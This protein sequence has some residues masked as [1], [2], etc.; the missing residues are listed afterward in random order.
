VRKKDGSEYELHSLR[1]VITSLDRFL[2]EVGT[3]ISI[4]K[5]REFVNSSKVMEG[6]ARFLRGQGY[7]KRPRASEALATEDEELLWSTERAPWQP[8]S[9][10]P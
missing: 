6:K 7:G 5:D 9:A 1:V 8:V 4:A 2:K 3:S 10:V